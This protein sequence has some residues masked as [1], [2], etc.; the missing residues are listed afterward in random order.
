M[1][2]LDKVGT[3]LGLAIVQVKK[4]GTAKAGKPKGR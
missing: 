4:T 2:G 1:E 3:C